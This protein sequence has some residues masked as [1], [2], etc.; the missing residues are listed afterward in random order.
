MFNEIRVSIRS[1]Q[2]AGSVRRHEQCEAL[3]SSVDPNCVSS[4]LVWKRIEERSLT[5]FSL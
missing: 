5:E 2:Y 3:P 1:D 4:C